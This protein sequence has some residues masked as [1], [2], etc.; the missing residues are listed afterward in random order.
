[1]SETREERVVSCVD[2]SGPR[3]T[4]DGEESPTNVVAKDS[5]IERGVHLVAVWSGGGSLFVPLPEEGSFLIGRGDGVDVRIDH[6]SV[7]RRHARLTM[8]RGEVRIEDLSSANGTWIAGRRL[9]PTEQARVPTGVAVEVGSSVLRVFVEDGASAVASSKGAAS[10]AVSRD[11]SM[12]RTYELVEVVAKSKLPV[13]LIGETGAGKERLAAQIHE[14]S[15]RAP[16]PFIK[17]NCAALAESLLEAELFGYERGAFTGANQAK[18]GLVEAANKGTLFLDEVGDMPA[19]TQA[20]ILR[21]LESGEVTRV[22]GVAPHRVDVRIVAATNVD[23]RALVEAARFRRDLYFRLDGA[24][25]L[26]PALRDR[27]ADVAPL[28][29]AFAEEACADAGRAPVLVGDDA[30]ERLLQ[31]DWPGNVREL[32]N[33]IARSVLFCPGT[34]LRAAD[35]RFESVSTGASV[36]RPVPGIDDAERR[37]ILEALESCAHNQTKAA[38]LLGISRRTLV[39]RLTALG[40]PRPR[41]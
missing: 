37:R 6:D 33:V 30:I 39:S 11:P 34:E 31:H 22:G 10:R 29:Q 14:A 15:R 5:V 25:I 21:V 4:T 32:R 16:E 35:L 23:L 27:P 28:A 2:V 40:V 36:T 17:V 13:L 20:K 1:M 26:V 9:A 19:S 12:A 3:A 41:K 8:S 38:K 7:S 24:T 18:A